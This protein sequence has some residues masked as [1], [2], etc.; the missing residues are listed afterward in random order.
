MRVVFNLL[1]VALIQM[2]NLG[3][4]LLFYETAAEKDALRGINFY[5]VKVNGQKIPL[6]IKSSRFAARN[7]L[8]R[9]PAIPVVIVKRRDGLE[10]VENK[11]RGVL[12]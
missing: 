4:I 3:E 9:F 12:A 10:A 7:H 1:R 5:V 2:I 8:K 6:Q 11:I